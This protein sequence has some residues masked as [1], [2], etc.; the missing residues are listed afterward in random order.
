M[1]GGELAFLVILSLAG[2]SVPLP[3]RDTSA[4]PPTTADLYDPVPLVDWEYYQRGIG[5]TVQVPALILGR[6]AS[7]D[8]CALRTADRLDKGLV[9]VLPGI[10]GRSTLNTSVALGV[11]EGG[12]PGAVVI[13]DWTTGIS[14]L[15]LYHLCSFERNRRQ[16]AHIADTI[17]AYQEH[18][19]GRPVY[20]IG[21]SGGGG[22]AVM[23]LECLPPDRRIAGAI[24]M[25]A[26]AC[27]Y[28]DLCT[29]LSHTCY[30]IWNFY[31]MKDMAILGAGTLVFGTIERCH[32]ISAGAIGFAPQADPA[33]QELYRERL[34]E[35]P[36]ELAMA[37][38]FHCGGHLGWSNRVFVSDWIA[39]L[40][41]PRPLHAK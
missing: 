34:H 20:L 1:R 8:L 29:A 5:S 32:T 17:V 36:Y 38:S 26:A 14:L 21:H 40:L 39:P 35:R 31:S 11:S 25:A 4:S 9:I 2:C 19:P 22:V 28:H 18:Y 30:G 33:A 13:H 37:P 41:D 27:P 7:P 23:A 3:T 12:W 6:L 16:A 24:L 15:Y 10:E